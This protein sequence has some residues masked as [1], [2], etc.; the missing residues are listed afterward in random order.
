MASNAIAGKHE[1]AR[2]TVR[3][4]TRQTVLATAL[5][6]ASSAGRRNKGLLGRNAL[7]T[8]GGLWIVPCQSVHTFFMRFAIDLVYL[9]R[10]KRVCKVRPSVGPWRIS[11][12]LSAHSVLE[13]PA[14]VVG[15]SQTQKGDVLEL[16]PARPGAPL[17]APATAQP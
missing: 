13:L 16:A 15:A 8:G 3:N 10:A 1:D 11:A 5:E 14:G 12:C 6:V 9:D 7:D 2:M 17:A 4:L